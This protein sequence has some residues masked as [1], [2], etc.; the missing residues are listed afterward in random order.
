MTLSI[1]YFEILTITVSKK[2]TDWKAFKFRFSFS[3]K[4]KILVFEKL[5]LTNRLGEKTIFRI[6]NHLDFKPNRGE[7]VN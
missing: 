6:H 3:T 7:G 5:L 1:Q 2:I 4:N